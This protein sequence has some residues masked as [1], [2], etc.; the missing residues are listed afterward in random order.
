MKACAIGAAIIALS[1]AT[2]FAQT[3]PQSENRPSNPKMASALSVTD[4]TFINKAVQGGVSEI[5]QARLALRQ[6]RSPAVKKVAQEMIDDHGEADSRLERIAREQGYSP[7]RE[8]PTAARNAYASLA[9]ENGATFDHAYV[10]EQQAA[11]RQAIA[12][13]RREA[14]AGNNLAVKH[15]AEQTLPTLEHHLAMFEA[16]E[17]RAE[18]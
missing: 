1:A 14:R 16:T 3:T 5:G 11:H 7:A 13:F 4:K 17:K 10:N 8:P 2:A 18:R 12:L 15:F 6:S 9:K